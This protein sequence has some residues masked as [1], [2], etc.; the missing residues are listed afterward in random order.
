MNKPALV[1]LHR[2]EFGGNRHQP[3]N[4]DPF[5]FDDKTAAIE[6]AV[7]LYR[8]DCGQFFGGIG[9]EDDE[10]AIRDGLRSRDGQALVRIPGNGNIVFELYRRGVRQTHT[11]KPVASGYIAEV[12]CTLTNADGSRERH[13]YKFTSHTSQRQG[14]CWSPSYGFDSDG[15]FRGYAGMILWPSPDSVRRAFK[16]YVSTHDGE[17]ELLCIHGVVQSDNGFRQVCTQ[18][19]AK[20]GRHGR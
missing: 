4:A 10:R 20:G 5:L 17:W 9:D 6:Y 11:D 15:N 3:D 1:L 12:R 18:Y 16:D 8:G 7:H 2:I 13:E 14:V 19:N